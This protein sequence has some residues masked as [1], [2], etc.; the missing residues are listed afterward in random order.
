M[1]I[2]IPQ[3]NIYLTSIPD[4]H[5]IVLDKCSRWEDTQR[6]LGSAPH[7]LR[8]DHLDVSVYAR[9]GDSCGLEDSYGHHDSLGC[10]SGFRANDMVLVARFAYLQKSISILAAK[11]KAIAG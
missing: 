3:C 2:G 8:T 11:T 4:M 7:M 9:H 1:A 10:A 6:V 5:A